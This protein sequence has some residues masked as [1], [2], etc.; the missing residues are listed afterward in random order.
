MCYKLLHSICLSPVMPMTN[1]NWMP[2]SAENGKIL[3]ANKFAYFSFTSPNRICDCFDSWKWNRHNRHRFSCQH[4]TNLMV[5]HSDICIMSIRL[6]RMFTFHDSVT[7]GHIWNIHI[8][9]HEANTY[10]W[11]MYNCTCTIYTNMCEYRLHIRTIKCS[12]ILFT[13][14][15]RI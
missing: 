4:R 10:T 11:H 7:Y 6:R 14:N 13:H 3:L 9:I 15:I 5:I 1:F 2:G 12:A 8:Y